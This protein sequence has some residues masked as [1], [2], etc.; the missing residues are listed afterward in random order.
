MYVQSMHDL[1]LCQNFFEGPHLGSAHLE[2]H[3]E[4]GEEAL[5]GSKNHKIVNQ[6]KKHVVMSRSR[7]YQLDPKFLSQGHSGP[8]AV[9]CFELQRF[10][11][12]AL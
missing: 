2:L 4:H 10:E 6:N 3:L 7:S 5:N 8:N 1:L 12:Q 11:I 9:C